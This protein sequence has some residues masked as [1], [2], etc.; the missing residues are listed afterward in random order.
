MWVPI[1]LSRDVPLGTT[2]AVILEGKER[3]VWRAEDGGVQVWEDRCPHR[4]MRLSLGFVRGSALNCLYHGWT[5]E[6]GA[7][8]VRIPA[9]PDLKVPP[10]II[11]NAFPVREAGGMIWTELGEGSSRSVVR[12]AAPL[13]TL[14]VDAPATAAL[15]HVG[16]EQVAGRQ[17]AVA[18]LD[19]IEFNIGWHAVSATKT[20]LH[21]ALRDDG[22]MHAALGIVRRLRTE[23]EGAFAA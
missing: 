23:I 6:T 21:T 22:D 19:G 20:M 1:A 4:G 14:A 15:A 16:G 17:L 11:A 8:C 3:V 10:S 13:V 7:R 2:R 12:G 9:H 5:Y 18:M